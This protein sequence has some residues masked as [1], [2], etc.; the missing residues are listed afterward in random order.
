MTINSNSLLIIINQTGQQ[1]R[2]N[3]IHIIVEV[4][5]TIITPIVMNHIL[6]ITHT[7]TLVI[8]M[9]IIIVM[10]IIMILHETMIIVAL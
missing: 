5:E 4:I 10:N 3:L 6:V 9:P 2:H 1:G 7:I 8:D